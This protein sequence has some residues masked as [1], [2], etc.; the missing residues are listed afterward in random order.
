M[1]TLICIHTS[2]TSYKKGW[3]YKN[4]EFDEIKGKI[5]DQAK[6]WFANYFS[7]PTNSFFCYCPPGN[8]SVVMQNND[9]KMEPILNSSKLL[10]NC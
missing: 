2:P 4:V 7:L 9:K 6:E 8:T 1:K 5:E 10:Q 3:Y